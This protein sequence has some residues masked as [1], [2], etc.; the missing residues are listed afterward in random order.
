MRQLA[1]STTRIHST[2]PI[3]RLEPV[4][5][6]QVVLYT[7]G[8][9]VL[10]SRSAAVETQQALTADPSDDQ[11]HAIADRLRNHALAATREWRQ[12]EDQPFE[13]ECLTLYLSNQCNL[14]CGYCYSAPPDEE[15]G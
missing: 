1:G 9:A 10:G 4:G 6:E 8:Y 12:L 15:R 14:A 2:L 11:S 3:F 13:P 5:G 7:P